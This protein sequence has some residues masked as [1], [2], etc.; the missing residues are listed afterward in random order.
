MQMIVAVSE[1]W[2]IGRENQLLFHISAD[3][4][5]FK[6]LT[7]GH[8]VIMGRKTL[9]G[10][11]GGHGLANR[12]N[13]VLSRNPAFR[14]EGA[15]VIA[16]PEQVQAEADAFCIGGESVYRRMLPLCDRVYVTKVFAAPAA[17]AFFPD[18]DADKDWRV[19]DIGEVMEENGLRFQYVTY[20]R[21]GR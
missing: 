13:L 17:D 10:L 6:A 1:N 20:E 18:L 4:R 14:P 19:A 12:R 16:A 2:G 8:T 3:L 5:R 11:P 21:A 15:E 9:Q 7:Q